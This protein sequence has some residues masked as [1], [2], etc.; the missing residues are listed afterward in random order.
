MAIKRDFVREGH[1]PQAISSASQVKHLTVIT[2]RL[3]GRHTDQ[4]NFF[5]DYNITRVRQGG[6]YPMRTAIFIR[7]K[8]GAQR[9]L[10]GLSE[11][12]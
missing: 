8:V 6:Y 12:Y 2:F 7:D 9:P 11:V 10:F 4:E 1:S 5:G 3:L